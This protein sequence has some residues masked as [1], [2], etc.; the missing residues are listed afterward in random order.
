[1]TCFIHKAM[2]SASP[3]KIIIHVIEEY[4]NNCTL[5]THKVQDYISSMNENLIQ[6]YI[7]TFYIYSHPH[8]NE[9]DVTEELWYAN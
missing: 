6:D 5:H 2:E 1:M 7:P 3:G 4:R 9:S 8:L